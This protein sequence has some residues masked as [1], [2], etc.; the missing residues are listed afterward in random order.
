MSIENNPLYQIIQRAGENS[1]AIREALIKAGASEDGV[2]VMLHLM[3]ERDRIEESKHELAKAMLKKVE[4]GFKDALAD[5]GS[6]SSKKWLPNLF[7]YFKP[8]KSV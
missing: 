3:A 1:G 8:K 5:L 6:K 7:G 2:D 4:N